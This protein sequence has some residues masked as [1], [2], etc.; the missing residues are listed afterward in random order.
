MLSVSLNLMKQ[1]AANKYL[2]ERALYFKSI[3][4]TER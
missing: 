2:F 1:F 4:V 3:N